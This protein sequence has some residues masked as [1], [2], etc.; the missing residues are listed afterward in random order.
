MTT[1]RRSTGDPARTVFLGSGSFA[2]PILEALAASPDVR[3]VAVVTAPD[4]PSGRR[5][6][7]TPTPVAVRARAMGIPLL[8]PTRIRAPDAV[9]AIA[10]FEPELGVLADYGQIVPRTILDMP[11][12]GILNIHPSLLPRHRGATPIPATIA[13]GDLVAGVTVML[14]DEGLDTG[15]IVAQGSWPLDGTER[16]PDLEAEAARRG[17]ELLGRVLRPWLAGEVDAVAQDD[18]AATLTRPFRREDGRLDPTR[19]A[20]TLE[21]QVRANLPWPGS[22]LETN[23]GRLAIL[24]AS[25]AAAEPDDPAGRLV[26]HDDRLALVSAD[27]RLVLDVVRPAGGRAMAGPDFLR[28]H[29]GMV[30]RAV[31]P[32]S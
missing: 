15:P 21:R 16:A 7:P 26:R 28:G 2:L 25:L 13:A 11:G 18:A 29:P 5:A 31:V 20:A 24:A 9:A 6:R 4:R 17:A 22:F 3:I 1:A 12:H 10:A 14:M 32:G 19:A 8:R 30:G 27:G 23:D